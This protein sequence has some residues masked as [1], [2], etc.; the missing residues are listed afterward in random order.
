MIVRTVPD[1]RSLANRRGNNGLIVRILLPLL[2]AV[3]LVMATVDTAAAQ[4]ASSS[5]VRISFTADR[6]EMTVG[7]VAI[8]SLVVSH[9]DDLVV[10]LPRLER[11]WG[12]FE[13][14][15]QTSVQT[16]SLDDGIKTIAKQFQVALF[17][18]GA[19]ETPDLPISI[20]NPDGSMEQVY[21]D[22][23][24]LTVNSVLAGPDE[25]LKDI[26]PPADLSTPLWKRPAVLVLAG[27][28]VVG[29]SVAV[30]FYVYRR[31]RALVSVVVQETDS[32]KPWEVAHQ[33]LDRIARL[34]LPESGDSKEHYTLVAG[35]LRSY[36]GATYLKEEGQAGGPDMSTEEIRAA[37]SRSPLDSRNSREVI[38]LLQE[39]DL[40]KFANYS[41]PAG[42][43]NE[44]VR[45]ARNFVD[46]TRPALEQAT[47]QY[48]SPAPMGGAT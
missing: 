35:T 7:D 45:Q 30:G 11:E 10:V 13:V 27:L 12:P 36:L 20:R 25:E 22:P 46:A 9:P 5:A 16:I 24:E 2:L 41:P 48:G 38:E 47:L 37:I 21:P 31:S 23:V 32:R 28:V 1:R 15:A 26:R 44:V 19:F 18:P 3:S 42:R 17:S 40:V 33:E 8:L 4:T 34:D 6:S 43:A 29:M 14:Q 39:A